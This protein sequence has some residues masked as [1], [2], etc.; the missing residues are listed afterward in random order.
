VVIQRFHRLWRWTR[1]NFCRSRPEEAF[2]ALLIE[3]KRACWATPSRQREIFK[4]YPRFKTPSECLVS[5][6]IAKQSNSAQTRAHQRR[7]YQ[8][9]PAQPQS[10]CPN[11]LFLCS[12]STI[13]YPLA[14]LSQ[15]SQTP[16]RTDGIPDYLEEG[17]RAYGCK[18][19]QQAGLLLKQ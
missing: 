2:C 11:T 13:P 18:M 12:M 7:V 3:T 9:P 5:P 15:I 1:S 17:L 14:S 16:S 19:I 10:S 4:T 6:D 8:Q